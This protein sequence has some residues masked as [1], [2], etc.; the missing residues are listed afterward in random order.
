[1]SPDTNKEGSLNG[2]SHPLQSKSVIGLVT[3]FY[4]V[5]EPNTSIPSGFTNHLSA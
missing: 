4:R 2:A 5:I 3:E 1:M